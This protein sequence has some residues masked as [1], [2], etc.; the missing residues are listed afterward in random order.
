[1]W[2]DTNTVVY[3]LYSIA[4]LV[5]WLLYDAVST[6]EVIKWDVLDGCQWWIGRDVAGS[7]HGLL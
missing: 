1:L 6:V 3:C 2:C 7:I 5:I 4:V